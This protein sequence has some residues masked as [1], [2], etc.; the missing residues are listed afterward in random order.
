[1]MNSKLS[2]QKNKTVI[3]SFSQHTALNSWQGLPVST[4]DL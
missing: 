3:L 2:T 4:N 1:M